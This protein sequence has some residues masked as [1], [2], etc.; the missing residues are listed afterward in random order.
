MGR[1]PGTMKEPCKCGRKAGRSRRRRSGWGALLLSALFVLQ[2]ALHGE[3]CCDHDGGVAE[4]GSTCCCAHRA[5]QDE[6][7]RGGCCAEVAPAGDDGV[8]LSRGSACRCELRTSVPQPGPSIASATGQA[9]AELL[10]DG[11]ALG[12]R[13][14]SR[15]PVLDVASDELAPV[16]RSDPGATLVLLGTG[17]ASAMHR[18]V[19]RGVSALLAQLSVARI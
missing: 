4:C 14:S 3:A 6:G 11:I 1:E 16:A 12:G 9:P 10:R 15:S 19:A 7:A 5:E 8:S 18:L 17:D 2:P 13:I